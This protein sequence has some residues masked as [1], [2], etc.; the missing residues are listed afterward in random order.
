MKIKIALLVTVLAAALFVDGC[1]SVATPRT[2]LSQNVEVK[3]GIYHHKDTGKT[4]T[5][6]IFSYKNGELTHDFFVKEGLKHGRYM[7]WHFKPEYLHYDQVY[8]NGKLISHKRFWH[9]PLASKGASTANHFQMI[10]A[11]WNQDGTP[12]EPG[13]EKPPKK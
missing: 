11:G 12:A 5:G 9:E 10:V 13:K 2:Y 6:R 3:S 4:V 8:E 7:E 1:A